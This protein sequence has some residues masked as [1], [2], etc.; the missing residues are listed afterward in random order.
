MRVGLVGGSGFIGRHLRTALIARGDEVVTAS[1]RSPSEAA[2]AV[3]TCD[4]V[5]NLA[6]ETIFQRWSAT[7]KQRIYSSRV[8]GTRALIDAL[9]A[10]ARPPSTY[11]SASAVGYY[12]PSETA[13]YTEG[14]LHG[15]DFLAKLCAAWETE[16]E[17][18]A[19]FGMRVAI[20]RTGVV[21]GTD[22][23]ALAAMLPAFRLGLGGMLGSGRQ[24]IP[25]IHVNDVTG[26]Y[27]LALDGTSG[28]LNATA[29]NPVTNAELTLALASVLHRPAFFRVPSFALRAALGEGA[30]ILLNGQRV[31]P[32]RTLE[33]GYM[34]AFTA[35]DE[36]LRDLLT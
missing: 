10:Q 11:I 13:S 33:S 16:A 26:I 6:G 23:G 19:Q 18:A 29:P 27:R 17:R 14:S 36:A 8:D 20:V 25:W 30:T 22:G 15:D 3:A 35:L 7:A 4:A 31:L 1:L 24:W 32:Q 2:A 28:V 5:V 12:P 9:A 21:L 34:F